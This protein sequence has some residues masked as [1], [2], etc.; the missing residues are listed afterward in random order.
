MLNV[1]SHPADL[2]DLD[3]SS[4]PVDTSVVDDAADDPTIAN[5]RYDISSYGIDFDVRGLV[6]RLQEEKILIP[7]FQ[8]SFVWNLPDASR[9]V[10]SLLLGLPV[11][12]IFLAKD[13][14]TN[15]LLVIDG[16][17]RLRSL[18]FFFE[19]F[20]NPH[21]AK[22]TRRVFRLS[23]VQEQYE[24]LTYEQLEERDRQALDDAVIH[25]TIVKQDQ[26]ADDDTSIYHVYERLNSGGRKL[27]PQEIRTAISHGPL[28]ES[29]K[30]LNEQSEWRT[31]FGAPS[32][33][34]KD[35]EMILRFLA[36]YY[37]R[38]SYARPMAE[39]LSKFAKRHR[40]PPV[41]FLTH[42]QA[43]FHRKKK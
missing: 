11:P 20:F 35:Q 2:P 31:L 15:K 16:Q 39:F 4:E 36:F 17:Q 37:D 38:E 14:E 30:K 34:L 6:G 13:P 3:P 28:I 29:I 21:P 42:A 12:G 5:V 25:A 19:G 10:E 27:T 33:R 32:A 40:R 26:P 24:N 7:H 8:R 9:F 43:H 22:A 23:N 41:A 1:E 18:Q